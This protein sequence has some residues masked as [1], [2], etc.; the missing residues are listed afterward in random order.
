MILV[1][2]IISILIYVIEYNYI[3]IYA[4]TLQIM[5]INI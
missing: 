3:H 1:N 5:K 4:L 2:C